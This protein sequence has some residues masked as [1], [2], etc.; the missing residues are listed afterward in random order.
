MRRKQETGEKICLRNKN[1]QFSISFYSFNLSFFRDNR[2]PKSS[3]IKKRE[4]IIFSLSRR[5]DL[6]LIALRLALH[7]WL[8]YRYVLYSY[9]H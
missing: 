2:L 3:Q 1:N 5:I 4:M 6:I 9:S 7:S 8:D